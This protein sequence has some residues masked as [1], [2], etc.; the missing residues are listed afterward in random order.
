MKSV[1]G[2]LPLCYGNLMS[3]VTVTVSLSLY[4]GIRGEGT[5]LHGE[6]HI[7]IHGRLSAD[8]FHLS[9]A[10]ISNAMAQ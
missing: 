8:Q 5:I 7:D 1:L 3:R 9:I 4:C 10:R 2:G 6:E